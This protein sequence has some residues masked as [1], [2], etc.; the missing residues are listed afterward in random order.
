MIL[1]PAID[2]KDGKCV[3]LL[4]G[5]MARATGV[6]AAIA[7]TQRRDR[8]MSAGFQA[9]SGQPVLVGDGLENLHPAKRRNGTFRDTPDNARRRRAKCALEIQRTQSPNQPP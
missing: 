1:F 9:V 8:R 2:L 7:Q 6:V 5:D 3:R 4:R